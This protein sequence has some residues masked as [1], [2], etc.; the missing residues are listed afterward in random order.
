MF[1][2]E[3]RVNINRSTARMNASTYLRSHKIDVSF[4]HSIKKPHVQ[5]SK[6]IK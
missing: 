1:T 6:M 2:I 3:A 4:T 5:E